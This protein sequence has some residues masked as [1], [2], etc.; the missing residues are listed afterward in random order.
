MNL[1]ADCR[2]LTCSARSIPDRQVSE[3]IVERLRNGSAPSPS[4]FQSHQSREGV[5]TTVV[6][7]LSHST[8]V[9]IIEKALHHYSGQP[10]SSNNLPYLSRS[11]EHSA[12]FRGNVYPSPINITS[13]VVSYSFPRGLF[14]AV[15]KNN[16]KNNVSRMGSGW[17]LAGFRVRFRGFGRRE[18]N[19]PPPNPLLRGP[20]GS[21]G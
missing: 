7:R 17:L 13:P 8:A 11:R 1:T 5:S 2:S 9:E 20:P 15:F 6:E 18:V 19:L 21:G 3:I 14:S 12:R 16:Q 10:F 4:H